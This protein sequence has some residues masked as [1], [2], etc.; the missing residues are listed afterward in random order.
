MNTKRKSLAILLMLVMIISVFPTGAFALNGGHTHTEECY[1]KE[2]DLLCNIEETEG[3]THTEDCY[4]PGGELICNHDSMSDNRG[5]YNP[6][7]K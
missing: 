3:H 5:G 2:G 1:A 4:C 6:I 7:R